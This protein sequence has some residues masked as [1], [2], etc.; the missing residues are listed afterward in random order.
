MSSSRN[1]SEAASPTQGDPQLW[2]C[3]WTPDV[4]ATSSQDIEEGPIVSMEA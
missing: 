3:P 4:K 1:N 2:K